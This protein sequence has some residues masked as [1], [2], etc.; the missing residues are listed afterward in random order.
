VK[1]LG[2]QRDVS[3]SLCDTIIAR[4]ARFLIKL[5]SRDSLTPQNAVDCNHQST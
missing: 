4:L 5:R 2:E 1:D 3:R